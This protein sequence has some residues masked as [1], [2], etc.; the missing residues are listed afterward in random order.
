[1]SIKSLY[2]L[3]L[4]FDS[5][6]CL[7]LRN[8]MSQEDPEGWSE[9]KSCSGQPEKIQ[10]KTYKMAQYPKLCTSMML[11][12]CVACQR[13][14]RCECAWGYHQKFIK[15]SSSSL[16]MII[17]IL[18][19]L[20]TTKTLWLWLKYPIMLMMLMVVVKMMFFCWKWWS[21]VNH[22]R[23]LLTLRL[24]MRCY[25]NRCCSSIPP[26]TRRSPAT[27]MLSWWWW[28]WWWWRC[29]GDDEEHSPSLP[30]YTHQWPQLLRWTHTWKCILLSIKEVRGWSDHWS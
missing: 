20:M 11:Q 30:S 4:Y 21:L 12:I 3:H 2:V 25:K 23:Q 29:V 10:I 14:C 1:M 18:T 19:T 6:I 9:Q 15:S 24:G 13:K 17:I 5:H 16:I 7:Y 8:R 22:F 28:R 27:Q 26:S